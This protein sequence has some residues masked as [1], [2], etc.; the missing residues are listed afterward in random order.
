MCWIHHV[1]GV[2]VY[3]L[4]EHL[5]PGVKII[6]FAAAAIVINILYL[7][8]EVL[9]NYIWDT[10]KCEYCFRNI[11]WWNTPSG[12]KIKNVLSLLKQRRTTEVPLKCLACLF[13][14]A[15]RWTEWLLESMMSYE[16]V[17]CFVTSNTN[18][19]AVGNYLRGLQPID[20]Q[21]TYYLMNPL[22]AARIKY[23]SVG[24]MLIVSLEK[25]Y[26]FVLFSG[27][28]VISAYKFTEGKRICSCQ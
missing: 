3:P 9:N 8:G 1:T 10:Q 14:K 2:W 7:V 24:M 4:L 19:R 18:L 6:F 17:F 22:N 16:Y 26:I 13:L 15:A 28:K 23:H 12:L 5:S 11:N 27:V 20:L 21:P 25:K